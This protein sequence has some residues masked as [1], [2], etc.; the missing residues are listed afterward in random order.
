MTTKEF[1]RLEAGSLVQWR[2]GKKSPRA[3]EITDVGTVVIEGHRR[4]ARWRDGQETDGS[5]DWALQN[6]EVHMPLDLEC[7]CGWKAQATHDEEAERKARGHFTLGS[8]HPVTC[9]SP[10]HGHPSSVPVVVFVG[11]IAEQPNIK[12]YAVSLETYNLKG[13]Q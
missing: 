3:G 1:K 8:G 13:A 12:R 7:P 5:D 2:E 11:S 9:S 6:V 4:F 10:A